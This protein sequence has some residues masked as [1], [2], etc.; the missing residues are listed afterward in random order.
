MRIALERTKQIAQASKKYWPT[1]SK[2]ARKVD[3]NGDLVVLD[4]EED[5][6]SEEFEGESD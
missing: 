4:E 5:G 3:Q 1:K 2:T 6:Y